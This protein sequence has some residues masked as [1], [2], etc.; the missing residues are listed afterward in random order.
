MYRGGDAQHDPVERGPHMG[1]IA[2]ITALV[3]PTRPEWSMNK[4]VKTL[5]HEFAELVP[6]TIYFFVV[7]HIIAIIRVLM[8]KGTGIDVSTTTSIAVAALILGK[9]VLLAN[10]LPFIN[11]YPERP[12]IWNVGWKTLLYVLI[13]SGIHYLERLYEFWKEAHGFIAANQKMLAEMVWPH[14]WAIQI[15]LVVLVV[16]YCVASELA[17]VIGHDEFKAMFFGP[18]PARSKPAGLKS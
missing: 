12:L 15:L 3:L 14:F 13:A 4:F 5:R 6:P 16:M 1:S 9:A 2:S 18:M 11:R 8:T 17:R 10:A 7:L